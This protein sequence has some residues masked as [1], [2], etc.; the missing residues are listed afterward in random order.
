MRLSVCVCLCVCCHALG[1]T[2]GW[3]REIG[4]NWTAN[5]FDS[6][7]QSNNRLIFCR[8]QVFIRLVQTL[9]IFTSEKS[10]EKVSQIWGKMTGKNDW[11]ND[12]LFKIKHFSRTALI[13][14]FTFH[15]H[16]K[17]AKIHFCTFHG[18]VKNSFSVKII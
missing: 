4:L 8:F 12:S 17:I 5:Q 10:S 14:I 13:F 7:F 3:I 15:G 2:F 11:K 16:R 9:I 1:A 6:G 18:K